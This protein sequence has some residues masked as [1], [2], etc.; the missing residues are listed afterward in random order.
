[1]GAGGRELW[2][3]RLGRLPYDEALELQRAAARARISG[4]LPQD[5]LLLVEHPPV[6]TLGRSSKAQH[7]LCTAEVLAARGISLFEVERGGD[8]TYHGPGQLVGYPIIDLKRHKQD[9][10]WYL[11]Q[12]EE[13]LISTLAFAGLS[14]ERDPGKTGVWVGG[15]KIASIGVHAR[16]WV[17]W[18]GFALNVTTE[19]S[20]FDVIVPCGISGV[21][22]TSI[23]REIET[24]ATSPATP[25]AGATTRSQPAAGGITVDGVAA[26]AARG[27]AEVFGLDAVEMSPL[28]LGAA[29]AHPPRLMSPLHPH[30]AVT[31]LAQHA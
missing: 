17:T 27:V 23:A 14:G 21:E 1:M 2:V 3:A 8:V 12:V 15:R 5:L 26:L 28:E 25:A 10:H 4:A 20:A 31:G 11:R 13:A 24:S 9:L 7:L 18:H 16:D 19:L 6:V 30:A 22:M 29:I